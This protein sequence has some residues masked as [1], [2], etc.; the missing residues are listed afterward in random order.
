MQKDHLEAILEDMDRKFDLILEGHSAL[1]SEIRELGRR[2]DERL[3]LVDFKIDTLNRKIDEV[4][5]KLSRK[6]DEVD[7]KLS[8]RIDAVDDKL[9]RRIDAVEEALSRK[10]DVVAADLG[11]HRA[12]TESHHGMYRV[13]ES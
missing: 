10:I 8:R 2:T 13:K 9:C 7:E 6:I 5:E 3:D 12:D 1:T 11:A 4:D